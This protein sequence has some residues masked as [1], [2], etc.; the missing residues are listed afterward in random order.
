MERGGLVNPGGLSGLAPC[1]DLMGAGRERSGRVRA[2]CKRC[3]E[4]KHIPD[5]GMLLC[6]DC[7]QRRFNC[8]WCGVLRTIT[9]RKGAAC[10]KCGR[11]G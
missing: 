9:G 11:T 6:A 8:Q 5:P 3:D 2:T 10:H 4:M 7:A 1:Q